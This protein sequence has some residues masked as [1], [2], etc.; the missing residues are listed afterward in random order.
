M[1]SVPLTC[2]SIGRVTVRSTTSAEAPVKV[3]ETWT[4]GGAIGGNCEIGRVGAAMTPAR[5]MR[6]AITPA[7]I[8]RS[9]K[10]STKA[11]ARGPGG[12]AGGG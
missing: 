7:K 8:G 12:S 10:N 9:M 3:A 11:G 1:C 2:S 6:I 4:D 5:M